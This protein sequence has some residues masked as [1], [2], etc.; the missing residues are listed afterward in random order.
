VKPYRHPGNKHICLGELWYTSRQGVLSLSFSSPF[1][2]FS[3]ADYHRDWAKF[4][5]KVPGE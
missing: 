4:M 1:I 5:G 3:H 2:A